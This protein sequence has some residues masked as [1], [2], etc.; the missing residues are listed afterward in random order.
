MNA[1][2]LNT[3]FQRKLCLA[4][5]VTLRLKKWAVSLGISLITLLSVING[6]A[7]ACEPSSK[8]TPQMGG[9][10]GPEFTNLWN[11]LNS[12]YGAN[13]GSAN[14]GNAPGGHAMVFLDRDGWPRADKQHTMTVNFNTDQNPNLKLQIG[15]FFHCQ[16]RGSRSQVILTSSD[17]KIVNMVESGGLVTFDFEV[18][19]LEGGI[20][21]KIDG[22]ITDIQI[23][24]P[25]YELNDPRLITDECRDYLKPLRLQ[26]IRLMGQSGCNSNFER[27][28]KY[29]TPA[30][31]PFENYVRNGND[32]NVGD[33]RTCFDERAN[34]PWLSNSLN[35]G[36]SFPWEKAID[37]CNYLDIDFYANLPVLV[38][39]NYARELAKLVKARLKPSLNMYIEIGNELWNFGGGGAFLG[40]A[41][42]ISA[43]H[44]MVQIEGDR[45][46]MG[47]LSKNISLETGSVGNGKWWGLSGFNAYEALRRWPSYRLKQF[48]DEFAKEFGSVDDGGVGGRIRAVLAGQI[49]YGWG[50]DYWFI[51]R[52]GIEFID[53][54]FGL[55]TSKKCFYGI[56]VANYF[57]VHTPLLSSPPNAT[58]EQ[59]E[60]LHQ[61]NLAIIEDVKKWSV[62]KIF[63]ELY[64][65]TNNRYGQIGAEGSCRTDPNGNCEGNELEDLLAYAKRSGLRVIAYEAGHETNVQ[66][67][68]AW[69]PLSNLTAAYNSE[70]M[71]E[72][73]KYELEKWYSWMGYDA[74]LIK[75]GFYT[76]KGYG[77]GYAVAEKEGDLSPQYRAYR[78]VVNNPAPPLTKERGGIIGVE[79]VSVLPGWQIASYDFQQLQN[80]TVANEYGPAGRRRLDGWK[81]GSKDV[82]I[83]R[84]ETSG[85]YGLNLSMSWNGPNS[86]YNI[87]MDGKLIRENWLL[88][89][90]ADRGQTPRY[91]DTL[92]FDI[93]YGTHAIHF[94]K[95]FY[96]AQSIDLIS[97]NFTLLKEGPPAKPDVI[98]GDLV[99]CKGNTKAKYEVSPVDF[100]VCDYEWS[101][102]PATATI[103]PKTTSTPVTGQGTYKMFVDWGSTPNG[104]YDLKV[105]GKNQ[106]KLPGNA[107][108][109]SPERIFKVTVQTCGFEI[110]KSPICLNENVTYTPTLIPD[111]KEY[112]W[113]LGPGATPN[114]SMVEP[115]NKA[116]IAKYTTLGTLDVKLTV[117]NAAGEDKIYFNVVNVVSCNSPIVVSPIKYCKGAT[118]SPLSA[119]LSPG[120]SDLKWYTEIG[121]TPFAAP[122]PS[123]ETIGTTSYW[124]TQMNNGGT[125]ES[126][127][128]K[129]D[130]T[131][132]DVPEVPLV[133]T[134]NPYCVGGTAKVEDLTNRVT[135][136]SGFTAK[137]Y[138]SSTAT[139]SASAP[140]AAST[141]SPNTLSWFVSQS[142]GTCESPKVELKVSVIAGPVFTATASNPTTCGGKGKITLAGLTGGASYK[143]SYNTTA[144]TSFTSTAAG[145]LVLDL[146]A[147]SYSN[148]KVDNSSCTATDSKTYTITDA[149]VSPPVVLPSDFKYCQNQ[150]VDV[151]DITSKVEGNPDY[152][153]SWFTALDGTPAAQPSVS[154]VQSGPTTIWVSQVNSVGCSSEKVGIDIQIN[155]GT[156]LEVSQE[157]PSTCG[158]ADGKLTIS[159]L[160]NAKE[161]KVEYKREGER[162]SINSISTNGSGQLKLEGLSAG[163]YTNLTA[164]PISGGGC[165]GSYNETITI[166]DPGA[167]SEVPSVN[168]GAD[169]CAGAAISPLQ[170]IP[171]NGGT[172]EWFSDPALTMSIATT[173]SFTPVDL[174]QGSYTYYVVEK[175]GSCRSPQESVIVSITSAPSK[176]ELVGTGGPATC[177]GTGYEVKLSGSESEVNYT[178]YKDGVP[179]TDIL[180]GTGSAL[181]FP[182]RPNLE[183]KYTVTAE[184][185]TGGCSAAMDGELVITPSQN[186]AVFEVSGGASG[187]EGAVSSAEIV[188]SGSEPNISY[189]I[190]ENGQTLPGTGEP[191]TFPI[192]AIASNNGIYTITALNTQ[193][194]C[195]SD[196]TKQAEIN[197]Q[198][199]VG[200]PIIT[201]E[202]QYCNKEITQLVAEV[203]NATSK[204][205]S[206]SPTSAGAINDGLVTWT[207]NYAGPV[208]ISLEASNAGCS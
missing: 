178:V 54:Q 111:A 131:I 205:W 148:I 33:D 199:G 189:K 152:S 165:L 118:A 190:K 34:N 129:I 5:G 89:H 132:S 162:K 207:E 116:V 206:L 183:G 180:P 96:E 137:W 179:S 26:V 79:K 161:Y 104:V 64:K 7:Q 20:Y 177:D 160:G 107:W 122:T 21:L 44:H 46:I 29:R 126:T 65:E 49:A 114:R 52:E 125:V 195:E 42:E 166:K 123:T 184:T 147:G 200:A 16:Y 32:D 203:T 124:V 145:N 12:G 159:G 155:P 97:M 50:Q 100:S 37:L 192:D 142:Q 58:P 154:T 60:A 14:M 62:D 112:R 85:S 73:T 48:M 143:V 10:I 146:A 117:K 70:K 56:A 4:I 77:A 193:T 149:V 67:W 47:D 82:Y 27:E 168:G 188:L 22:K 113:D 172:I 6:F 135:I 102:L 66:Y 88:D 98:Y 93:P 19:S 130:V 141:S 196:M 36:R 76:Q 63:E 86:R 83:I 61:Q 144:A 87:Y 153:L 38:D 139:T 198:P 197:I 15:D 9:H 3:D 134:G 71:Y 95:S 208:T 92:K 170:A 174:E 128:S 24:R 23:M 138:T 191:I 57:N 106:S 169:Y 30:N 181:V 84:N 201:G 151:S 69:I 127:P 119:E 51:G 28:W 81:A 187:C 120:G 101:G 136:K 105:V 115:T 45:T 2:K 108:L 157:D 17:V 173:N 140:T 90:P 11:M 18:L 43:V 121:G 194:G 204:T 150:M 8:P 74:L 103:L 72:H 78:D 202:P 164:T 68:G 94:A 53:K 35:Q 158:L 55:G 185:K 1:F 167:P 99:V 133:A 41:M 80:S 25:G 39:L 40:F 156:T 182:T 75:N 176:Q 186:P 31:A 109:T 163:K 13:Y 59:D 110:D 175:V 171:Q 91:S